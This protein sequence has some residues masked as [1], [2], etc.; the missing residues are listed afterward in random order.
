MLEGKINIGDRLTW[1][2]SIR[3]FRE[4]I[5]VTAL[6]QRGDELWI[7]TVNRHGKRCWNSEDII[8]DTCVRRE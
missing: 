4:D 3:K 6:Q 7:E 5:E 1:E 2:P 8:R